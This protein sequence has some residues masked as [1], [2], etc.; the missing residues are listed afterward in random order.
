MTSLGVFLTSIR[1]VDESVTPVGEFM[2]SI[3]YFLCSINGYKS[4]ISA[5]PPGQASFLIFFEWSVFFP[6]SK[7]RPFPSGCGPL[8]LESVP[9][10]QPFDGSL[11]WAYPW[12]GCRDEVFWLPFDDEFVIRYARVS[13]LVT[14]SCRWTSLILKI[15]LKLKHLATALSVVAATQAYEKSIFVCEVS[16]TMQYWQNNCANTTPTYMIKH[17]KYN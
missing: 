17:L 11:R 1:E 3:F 4:S 15:V 8:E 14:W 6:T 12:D 2:S 13:F 16:L 7:W 10:F 5:S 9:P